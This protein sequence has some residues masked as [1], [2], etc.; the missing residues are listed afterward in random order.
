MASSPRVRPR[1]LLVVQCLRAFTII[2]FSLRQ[3]QYRNAVETRRAHLENATRQR[4]E[5]TWLLKCKL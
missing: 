5:K 3:G 1:S 4:V 2:S